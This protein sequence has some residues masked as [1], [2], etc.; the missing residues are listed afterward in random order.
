MRAA[1]RLVRANTAEG[2]VCSQFYTSA[3]NQSRRAVE[4][5]PDRQLPRLGHGTT[6]RSP[7][8]EAITA[9]RGGERQHKREPCGASGGGRASNPL[10][11]SSDG[12]HLAV[13]LI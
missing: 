2:F 11:R 5:E 1:V 13:V 12:L 9:R 3:H 7:I 6:S 4:P 8:T 10:R